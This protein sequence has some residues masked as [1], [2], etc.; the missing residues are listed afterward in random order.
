MIYLP[1]EVDT[2]GENGETAWTGSLILLDKEGKREKWTCEGIVLDDRRERG[3]KD[4]Y[5]TLS[6]ERT[7]P[8]N[9]I[10]RPIMR[11]FRKR[12]AFIHCLYVIS[13]TPFRLLEA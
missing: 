2:D 10:P 7:Y 11:M 9:P 4:A 1:G 6:S 3:Q 8:N 13:L 12:R 5:P